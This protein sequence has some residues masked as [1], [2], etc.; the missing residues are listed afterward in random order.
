[1]LTGMDLLRHLRFFVTVADVRHFGHAADDLRMTQPP[2]SQ[3]IARLESRL[4]VRLFDRNARGV[5]ITPAGAALLPLAVDLVE[6]SERFEDAASQIARTCRPVL[7]GLPHGLGTIGVR[8]A[9]AVAAASP[10]PVRPMF[11]G[12]TDLVEGIV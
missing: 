10:V 7:L 5:H 8:L 11:G 2:L 1:M 6:A 12:S 4:D 3:G 9:A